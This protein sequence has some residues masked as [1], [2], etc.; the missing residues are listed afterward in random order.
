MG[1]KTV[2]TVLLNSWRQVWTSSLL[3]AFR[4]RWWCSLVFDRFSKSFIYLSE[5]FICMGILP[6]C[7]LVY[8]V[9]TWCPEEHPVPLMEFASSLQPQSQVLLHKHPW[10]WLNHALRTREPVYS[11]DKGWCLRQV[12]RVWAVRRGYHLMRDL[13]VFNIYIFCRVIMVIVHDSP[14][15]SFRHIQPSDIV[16]PSC[17][18]QILIGKPCSWVNKTKQKMFQKNLSMLNEFAVWGVCGR[19]QVEIPFRATGKVRLPRTANVLV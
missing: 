16:T 6:M 3:S 5:L 14:C 18:Q 10:S 12:G 19:L 1:T 11:A 4:L 15:I 17:H 7:M 9:H 13:T 8:C 2:Q